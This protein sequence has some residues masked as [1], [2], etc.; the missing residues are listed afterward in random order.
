MGCQ[1]THWCKYHIQKIVSMVIYRLVY[2]I[3]NVCMCN[4]HYMYEYMIDLIIRMVTCRQ[5]GTNQ[6]NAIG[7]LAPPL[8]G[9]QIKGY[10]WVT[11]LCRILTD[12]LINSLT[13][14]YSIFL[15][16][17]SVLSMPPVRF[18]MIL[19]TQA[20]CNST[21]E[22]ARTQFIVEHFRRFAMI[23]VSGYCW[24]LTYTEHFIWLCGKTHDTMLPDDEQIRKTF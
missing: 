9:Q 12:N 23:I 11:I 21:F 16:T 8:G 24:K 20:E 10:E 17:Y 4:W 2:Y 15:Q 13:L 18:F 7:W 14:C 6:S 5:H 1:A 3:C 19:N 22:T